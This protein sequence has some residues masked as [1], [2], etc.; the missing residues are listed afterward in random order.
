MKAVIREKL[1]ALIA[2]I[3]MGEGSKIN[4]II[5]HLRKLQKEEQHKPKAG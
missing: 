2:S 5:F 3:Q 4:N 1:I